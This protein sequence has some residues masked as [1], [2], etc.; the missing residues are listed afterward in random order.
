MTLL[1]I[2]GGRRNVAG[3]GGRGEEGG[4]KG[5]GW[6]FP[7]VGG[8]TDSGGGRGGWCDPTLGGEYDEEEAERAGRC[9]VWCI[10]DEEGASADDG[11]GGEDAGGHSGGSL[12]A[13]AE[14][15]AGTRVWRFLPTW[16][17]HI[18]WSKQRCC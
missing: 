6:Y 17:N 7:V 18:L 12:H 10:Q 2:L 9:A 3:S 14:R 8:E 4:G 1:E 13:A 16:G 11:R 5:E 15:C